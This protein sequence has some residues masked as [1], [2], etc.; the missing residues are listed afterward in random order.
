MNRRRKM[1]LFVAGLPALLCM[2]SV[3]STAQQ[4]KSGEGF[5]NKYSK[6]TRLKPLPPGGPAPRTADGHPDFSGIWFTGT[7]GTEDA[8]LVGSYGESDPATRAFDPKVTPEEKP[9]FT[10]WGAAK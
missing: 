5:D 8:T 6:N 7:L 2:I 4:Q 3:T 10:P 1:C 9:S